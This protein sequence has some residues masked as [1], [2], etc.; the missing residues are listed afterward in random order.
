MRIGV[1]GPHG[2]GKT[3]LVGEL[4]AQLPGHVPADEPYV[5][6][7]EAGYDVGFP[8]SLEDYRAQLQQSMRMLSSSGASVVF[9]RTPV[10]FLAY[11]A[12]QGAD[13]EDEAD[14]AALR[15]ALARLDLLVLT[16]V[17]AETERV[18]PRAEMPQLRQAVNDTL[19]DLVYRDPLHA[20]A[21]VP[22]TEL[23]GPLDQRPAAVL[24]ALPWHARRQAGSPGV[25]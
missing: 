1:S 21:G 11:L 12:A 7:E 9:D 6:L 4:C 16:P 18:L 5:L 13:L 8:P 24:A 20:W 10:D 3:T 25:P 17:T 14:P 22:V 23:D 19:L 15:S 2:T